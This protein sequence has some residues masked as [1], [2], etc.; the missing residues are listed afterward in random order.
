MKTYNKQFILGT[1]MFMVS[2]INF[3]VSAQ[4]VK[5][6]IIENNPRFSDI[7]IRP[8][9]TTDVG[10]GESGFGVGL[11]LAAE[12]R[13]QN[14]P[15]NLRLST[16]RSMLGNHLTFG[17][18][19]FNGVKKPLFGFELG[20][21]YPFL[22]S[23]KEKPIKV[24]LKYDLIGNPSYSNTYNVKYIKVNGKKE[25]EL[26]ARTGFYHH[27]NNFT[28]S[29]V[30]GFQLLNQTN[31]IDVNINFTG[32][33]AGV[34][35]LNRNNIKIKTEEYG[36]SQSTRHNHLYIDLIVAPF[37]K[38]TFIDNE[39][40][41]FDKQINKEYELDATKAVIP[42]SNVGYRIGWIYNSPKQNSLVSK[43]YFKLE[44]GKR[45]SVV[46]SGMFFIGS[47]GFA[48]NKT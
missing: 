9:F 36:I 37:S 40:T 8:N 41:R 22:K 6:D 15:V 18:D 12:Y 1:I 38:A 27:R 32:F 20:A 5:Y 28:G 3:D 46:G 14:L 23:T 45:P 16:Y 25:T 35:L 13:K 42:T 43:M 30:A 2:F 10:F 17:V 29:S 24:I 4:K 48:I 39:G 26:L 11:G 7:S 31:D 47:F 19:Y 44:A 34:A 33:Y 21:S